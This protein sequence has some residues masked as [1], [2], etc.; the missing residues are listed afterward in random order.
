[1]TDTLAALP[2]FVRYLSLFPPPMMV[3]EAAV[4]GPLAALGA[5]ACVLW[6][7]RGDHLSALGSFGHTPAEVHRYSALPL[8]LDVGV[9]AAVNSRESRVDDLAAPW[10][11]AV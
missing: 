9:C 7:V 8:F 10:P 2:Q 3:V 11:D 1:M 4:R 6:Q 5:R